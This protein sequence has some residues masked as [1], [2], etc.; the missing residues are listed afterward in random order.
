MTFELIVA[1][2]VMTILAKATVTYNWRIFWPALL[3]VAV[4]FAPALLTIIFTGDTLVSLFSPG[5]V[6]VLVIQFVVS[7]IVFYYMALYNDTIF[8]W[9]TWLIGG[10][11][12]MFMIVPQLFAVVH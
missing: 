11:V 8:V 5:H 3:S 2:M 9:L 7:L 4:P 12:L 6:L 10:G 1:F